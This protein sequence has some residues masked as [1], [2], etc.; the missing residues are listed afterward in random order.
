ME[1]VLSKSSNPNKKYKVVITDGERK[2]T[3]HFGQAGA[4][5]YTIHKDDERK[6]R[7][8]NRHKGMGENW[9]DPFTAGFWAL[10]A[11]WNK[12]T[13]SASLKDI[14]DKFGIKIKKAKS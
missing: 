1:A 8:I 2:K 5:D 4:E 6:E 9:K 13:L 12:P 11:L 3:I 7:Y 14:K 10:H